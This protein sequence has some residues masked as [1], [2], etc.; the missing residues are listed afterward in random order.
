MKANLDIIGHYQVKG[1]VLENKFKPF[2]LI[3]DERKTN[4]SNKPSLF[5]V[6]KTTAE[7]F[8][9]GKTDQYIS[10]VYKVENQPFSRIEYQG[11][12]YKFV[13]T[14]DGATIESLGQ[15]ATNI[16]SHLYR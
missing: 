7:P 2:R 3:L 13:I 11:V 10:S 12:Q 1:R 4:V 6:A 8:N 16:N 15:M 9:T 14:S 5:L